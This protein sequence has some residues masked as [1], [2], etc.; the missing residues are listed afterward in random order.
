[1]WKKKRLALCL[2]IRRPVLQLTLDVESVTLL[3][4]S[5]ADCQLISRRSASSFIEVRVLLFRYSFSVSRRL[6]N[7]LLCSSYP[8]LIASLFHEEVHLKLYDCARTP[9]D[10]DVCLVP[11]QNS[12]SSSL[13]LRSSS[14]LLCMYF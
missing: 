14:L 4:L 2:Y 5:T 11:M 3:T 8:S 1:M 10:V 6:W 13:L 12:V 7:A 9:L